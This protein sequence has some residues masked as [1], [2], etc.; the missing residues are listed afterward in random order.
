MRVVRVPE[1][2][3]LPFSYLQSHHLWNA[4]GIVIHRAISAL[5]DSGVYLNQGS[6][7]DFQRFIIKL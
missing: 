4:P 3:S 7:S 6:D 1:F 2:A 5:A